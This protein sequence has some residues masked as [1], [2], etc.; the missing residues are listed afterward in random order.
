MLQ[1]WHTFVATIGTCGGMNHSRCERHH[2]AP[3]LLSIELGSRVVAKG[4]SHKHAGNSVCSQKYA[5]RLGAQ[6]CFDYLG[7]K[8]CLIQWKD[9]CSSVPQKGMMVM[10]RMV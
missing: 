10:L 1:G 7:N 3:Q 9:S 2:P 8:A 4:C 5:S 6:H